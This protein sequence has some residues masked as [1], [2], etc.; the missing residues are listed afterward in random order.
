M[1]DAGGATLL[2][3]L[4]SILGNRARRRNQDHGVRESIA[5]V[6][7]LIGAHEQGRLFG[8]AGERRVNVLTLNLALD[9]TR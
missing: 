7:A 9:R 5:Q 8:L 1:S 4:G 6:E 2:T 3:R